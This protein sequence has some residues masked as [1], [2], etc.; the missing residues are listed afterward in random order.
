MFAFRT[1][2]FGLL[3]A[4]LFSAPMVTAAADAAAARSFLQEFAPAYVVLGP[5]SGKAADEERFK[6]AFD[7]VQRR[8]PEYQSLTRNGVKAVAAEMADV[9][10]KSLR[11]RAMGAF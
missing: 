10:T 5:S 8:K 3:A 11:D 7:D 9:E 6:R 4:Y 1:L 2:F